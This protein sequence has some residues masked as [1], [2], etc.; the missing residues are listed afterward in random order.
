MPD[1]DRRVLVGGVDGMYACASDDVPYVPGVGVC[2]I[3]G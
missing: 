3:E 2:G 1:K